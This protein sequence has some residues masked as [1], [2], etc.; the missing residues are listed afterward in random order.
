MVGVAM[1][2]ARSAQHS[3]PANGHDFRPRANPRRAR[4]AAL[5]VNQIRPSL[6]KRANRSQCRSI[7]DRFGDRRGAREAGPLLSQPCF[8]HRQKRRA[9]VPAHPQTF[10]GALAIDAAISNR[11]SM[12]LTDSSAIGKIVAAFFPRR[13]LAAMSANSKNCR[14]AWAQHNG[15]VI[16]PRACDGSYS[17]L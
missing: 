9:L 15:A 6:M 16:G 13:A 1:A 4:S 10:F 5:L 2:A 14:R 7:V 8:R 17:S 11:A 3:E 12:R